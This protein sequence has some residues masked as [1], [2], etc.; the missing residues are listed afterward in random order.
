MPGDG[1]DEAAV[2][3]VATSIG[4]MIAS[5]S[6]TAIIPGRNIVGRSEVRSMTVDSMPTV[7]GPASKIKSTASPSDFATC[8]P[9]VGE[10]SIDR[11]ALGAAT[12]SPL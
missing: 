4:P 12:G 6:G 7:V 8:A 1:R 3:C 9:V 11:L 10:I 2:A 5:M